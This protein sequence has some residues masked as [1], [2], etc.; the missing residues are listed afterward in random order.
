MPDT[1]FWLTCVIPLTKEKFIEITEY[2]SDN[3]IIEREI[4]KSEDDDGLGWI[5]EI[6][7]SNPIAQQFF[8]ADCG[9]VA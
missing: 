5:R 2:L 9:A 7:S 1:N 8:A 4:R 3:L 6:Q